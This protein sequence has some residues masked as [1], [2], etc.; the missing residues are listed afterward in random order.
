MARPKNADGQR[1][2]QAILDAALTLFADKGY[3]GTSLRDVATAV[4]VRESALYNY[5][6]S[7]E[8]LFDALL[9]AH[10][11]A[12]TERLATLG[13]EGPIVDGRALLERIAAGSLE[14]FLDPREQMLFRLLM[15]DGIRLARMGRF[16]LQERLGTGS[17]RMKK[18]MRRLISEGWLRAADPA[19]LWMTFF[20]PLMLWRQVHSAGG[21]SPMIRNPRAFARQHVEQFFVGA[22]APRASRAVTNRTPRARVAKPSRR[23]VVTRRQSS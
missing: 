22:G 4:G 21:D 23:P 12:R 7:K 19:L 17:E 18:L 11:Q 8:A 16:N 15:S 1:T 3:F 13:D 6:K 14:R 9:L 2:R 10:E 20:G 5:F